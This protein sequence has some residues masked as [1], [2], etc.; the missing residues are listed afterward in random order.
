MKRYKIILTFI[1]I[2][3]YLLWLYISYDSFR[4][5]R[6]VYIA[7]INMSIV[8][9]KDRVKININNIYSSNFKLWNLDIN[10]ILE[11]RISKK[12]A[13]SINSHISNRNLPHKLSQFHLAKRKICLDKQCWEFMGIISI[14][15]SIEVTLLS[16]DSKQKMET[17]TIGDELLD[18]LVITKIEGDK[19]VVKDNKKGE[20]FILKVFDVDSSAYLPKKIKDMNNE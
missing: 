7:D 17:F 19:M 13:K 9:I 10:K 12:E 20:K 5:S 18:G 15:K 1:F 11:Y 4:K 14:G 16:G 3:F 6:E 2:I 8:D